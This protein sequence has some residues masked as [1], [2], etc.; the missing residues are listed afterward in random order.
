MIK[1]YQATNLTEANILR[2]LLEAH[3]IDAYVSGHYLQGGI[4]ELS[5]MDFHGLLVPDED[6]DRARAVIKDYEAGVF[7][8]PDED[9]FTA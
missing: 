5:A 7:A 2:G 4:G 9:S 1:I 6:A 8:L 3:G